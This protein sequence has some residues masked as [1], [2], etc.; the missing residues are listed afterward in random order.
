MSGLPI[1][2]F[3]AMMSPEEFDAR[4][5][6]RRAPEEEQRGI[7]FGEIIVSGLFAFTVAGIVIGLMLWGQ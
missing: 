1:E 2:R 5:A 3:Q 4:G 7:G 6:E